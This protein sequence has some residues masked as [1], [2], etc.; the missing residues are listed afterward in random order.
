MAGGKGKSGAC[1][2]ILPHGMV[3]RGGGSGFTLPLIYVTA[4]YNN[5]C[6][7][8]DSISY[9]RVYLLNINPCH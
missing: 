8:S 4:M 9:G 7:H 3:C 1:V 5:S 6:I 2:G